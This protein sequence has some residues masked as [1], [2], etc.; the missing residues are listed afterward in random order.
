M[1]QFVGVAREYY[2]TEKDKYTTPEQ[3]SVAHVLIRADKRSREEAL[4]LAQEIRSLAVADGADFTA[5]ARK[6]S[7]RASIQYAV[8]RV[9]LQ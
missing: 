1:L 8:S 9:L 7:A 6:Y 5:L 2:L 4:K 3:V